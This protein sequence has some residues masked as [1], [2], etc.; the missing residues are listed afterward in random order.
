MKNT[1]IT[2]N[3]SKRRYNPENGSL[4]DA[5]TVLNM[6]ECDN[7][8]MPVGNC[9]IIKSLDA[10]EKILLIIDDNYITCI[11]RNIYFHDADS[12]TIIGEA[13]TSIISAKAI[14]DFIV[15]STMTCLYYL[16]RNA[17]GN[18]NP[19][20]VD[21]AIPELHFG[22]S[23]LF[24]FSQPVAEYY[25]KN[26][27]N[28]WTAPLADT[29]IKVYT[30][31]VVDA[32]SRCA[33]TMH[34][35]GMWLQPVMVRCA[36]RLWDNSLLWASAPIIV[37]N[38]MQC[39]STY[40]VPVIIS[41]SA[42]TALQ[43]S[44]ITMQGYRIGLKVRHG[45]NALWDTLIKSIEIYTTREPDVIQK[46]ALVDY[47]CSVT[48]SGERKYS[49]NYSLPHF[50]DET[51][52]NQLANS[53]SW[54][55]TAT[56]TDLVSLRSGT[57]RSITITPS[58]GS[59]V[60]ARNNL[61]QQEIMVDQWAQ[62][63]Y[64][65]V[66]P[67][68][69]MTEG[70][71]LYCGAISRRLGAGWSLASMSD[72]NTDSIPC[73]AVIVVT[74]RTSA[75]NSTV[76]WKGSNEV[77]TTI[78]SPIVAYPDSRA[79]Y[80]S[81]KMLREGKVWQWEGELTASSSGELA[82]AVTPA[83]T[84]HELL[85]TANDILIIPAE[86]NIIEYFDNQL[87]ISADRNPFVWQHKTTVSDGTITALRLAITPVATSIFGKYPLYAFTSQGI[88]AL[89]GNSKSRYGDP[90]CI[91]WHAVAN[92]LLI[93]YTAS[94]ITFIADNELCSLSGSKI[95][96]MATGVYATSIAWSKKYN[97]LWC[98]DDKG[99]VIIQMPSGRFYSRDIYIKELI[100]NYYHPIAITGNNAMLD[101]N[102]E[103]ATSQHII[104]RSYPIIVDFILKNIKWHVSGDNVALTLQLTGENGKSCHGDILN[105][106]KVT[107]NISAP[108]TI[109][110]Y[111]PQ[112][113]TIRIII[114]GTANCD[115]ML[116]TVIVS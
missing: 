101:I 75:G 16:L 88:Y 29:D 92:E 85:P 114:D 84:P 24:T 86:E 46:N 100:E 23:E 14:G 17:S 115:T 87:I 56:I 105:K 53:S 41:G 94:G 49:L 25:F 57:P 78:L 30:S 55:L 2:F 99:S 112:R 15:V 72:F 40:N 8:L 71:A 102:A 110:L 91:D 43:E 38:G 62:I 4:G 47:R 67:D 80:M 76:V 26:A 95:E 77:S 68:T 45:T 64:S 73:N 11:G 28:H 12:R 107:G 1:I 83:L 74:L 3:G 21:D 60:I 9:N 52:T 7:T 63:T 6:R 106:M 36:V 44:V 19:I 59:Y 18:Y 20:Y 89:A 51:I 10:N 69:M 109:P 104:Y 35:D 70:G 5:E 82:Y 34:A 39:V 113:R 90:R 65:T 32:M 66:S 13:P 93:C 50:D 31:M 61:Y 37:G 97:E 79:R 81:I 22:T 42:F 108:I 54:Q 116:H 48:Q 96:T 58:N 27:Y 33:D 98:V 103:Q 111:A